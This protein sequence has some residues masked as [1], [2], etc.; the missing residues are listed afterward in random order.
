[1]NKEFLAFE[2]L[3]Y[4]IMDTNAPNFW[5]KKWL[6][7]KISTSVTNNWEKIEGNNWGPINFIAFEGW[8]LGVTP[9]FWWPI[10]SLF[11]YVKLQKHC[12]L[13]TMILKG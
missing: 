6:L 11:I 3:S 10:I 12:N 9:H 13:L 8:G 5:T 4:R 2:H 1:M 7:N